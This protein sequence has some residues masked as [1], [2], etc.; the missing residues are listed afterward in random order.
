MT[1]IVVFLYR[2]IS[3]YNIESKIVTTKAIMGISVFAVFDNSG[4]GRN[5]QIVDYLAS[6]Q[7]DFKE[8]INF[9]AVFDFQPRTF[10]KITN[11]T[12]STAKSVNFLP[13]YQ[14]KH[15]MNTNI[16]SYIVGFIGTAIIPLQLMGLIPLTILY[17]WLS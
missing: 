17:P 1:T 10:T 14:R 11:E 16:V 13:F 12:M 4:E 9:G 8:L 15:I 6:G 2:K 3:K 5:K 7:L